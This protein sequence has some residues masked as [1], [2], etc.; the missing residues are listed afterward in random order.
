MRTTYKTAK[1]IKPYSVHFKGWDLEI[2]AGS[3]VSNETAGGCDDKYRFWSDYHKI[4][5]EL[6][7]YHTSILRHDLEHYGLNIPAEYCEPYKLE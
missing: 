3:I 5:K 6:T 4:A 1:T 2:P 7:G